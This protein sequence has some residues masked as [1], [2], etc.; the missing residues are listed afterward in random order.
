MFDPLE[1]AG[2][3]AAMAAAVKAVGAVAR[4]AVDR[5]S[6]SESDERMAGAD[7]QSDQ[8]AVL[9]RLS[10]Y[11]IERVDEAARSFLQEQDAFWACSG[12]LTQLRAEMQRIA[13]E[14][15]LSVSEVIEKMTPGGDFA[16]LGQRFN[17]AVRERPDAVVR[18]KWMDRAL[19]SYIRHYGRAQEE[20]VNPEM[21]GKPSYERLTERLRKAQQD[22]ESS[23]S[24]V[25]A[26]DNG[27]GELEPSHLERLKAAVE[28][29]TERI[30]DVLHE[31]AYMVRVRG[32]ES[33]P[34]P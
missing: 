7:P 8:P 13:R 34:A 33:D 19:E 17:E 27:H 22:M 24:T 14:H 3:A 2:L 21:S 30:K 12:K 25:P 18:K 5:L 20:V 10:E 23:V 28:S 4:R 9:P 29:V 11:R 26:F 32:G 6:G 16:E 15:F 1:T 31:Y